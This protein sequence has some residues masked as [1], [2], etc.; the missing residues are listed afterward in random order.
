MSKKPI[1]LPAATA[2]MNLRRENKER[3]KQIKDPLTLRDGSKV[4]DRRL[5]LIK[6]RLDAKPFKSVLEG[7]PDDGNLVSKKWELRKLLD[8]GREGICTATAAIHLVTAEPMFARGRDWRQAEK[9]GEPFV[10]PDLDWAREHIYW[11]A[12]RQDKYR[13]G[14]YPESNWYSEGS[15]IITTCKV[16]KQI[17]FCD[18]FYQANDMHGLK[19]GVSHSGPCIIGIPWFEQMFY[20]DADGIL[21]VSGELA[22]YHAVTV[23]E[24]D[25]E[26]KM[27]GFANSWGDWGKAGFGYLTFKDMAKL[28]SNPHSEAYFLAGRAKPS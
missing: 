25:M 4:K 9:T 14:I 20:P 21:D 1:S 27:F 16:L 10:E 15:D 22:G 3:L 24:I 7:V 8:Q 2:K 6:K 5:G 23:L 26:R 18:G 17:H 19:M 11:P 12:Q 13:G 28:R